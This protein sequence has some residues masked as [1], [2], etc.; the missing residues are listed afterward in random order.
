MRNMTGNMTEWRK[1]AITFD[2]VGWA[3]IALLQIAT[4]KVWTVFSNGLMRANI[5]NFA[6]IMAHFSGIVQKV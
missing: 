3:Y 1:S 6:G 4:F 2:N 5:T